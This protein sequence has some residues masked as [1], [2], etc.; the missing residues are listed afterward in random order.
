MLAGLIRRGLDIAGLLAL[1]MSL[2]HAGETGGSTDRNWG[3][4]SW[5]IDTEHLF[6]FLI[7]TDVG[8]VGAHSISRTSPATKPKSSLAWSFNRSI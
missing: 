2:A 3:I 8:E 1:A 7:G 6:G 4:G 5:R